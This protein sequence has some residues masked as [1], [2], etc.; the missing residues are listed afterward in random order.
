MKRKRT[1]DRVKELSERQVDKSRLPRA[2]S[3][4]LSKNNL[5]LIIAIVASSF[6]I[7]LYQ[8]NVQGLECEE[9][10]TIPAATGHHYIFFTSPPEARPTYVPV[11]IQE[12]KNLL[13]PDPDKSL[14]DVTDVLSRNVHM[15]LYFFLMHYW[16]KF[17]GTSEWS[18]RLP[19][20]IFGTLA[21]MMIFLLGRELI[22]PFVGLMSALL[23]AFMPDQ[24]Y[25]S[26][27]A[28]MYSL[29]VLLVTSSAYAIVITGKR[30]ASA[31]V[32]VLYALTSIAGLYTHYVYVFCFVSQVLFIWIVALL[33][34][35]NLRP[36]L[37]TQFS[38]VVASFPWFV[39]GLTQKQTSTDVI[40]W[41][42][43]S[44]PGG[45]ILREI[46]S[47]ITMLISVPE[48]PLGWLNVAV[49]YTLFA[50]GGV[51]LWHN[52]SAILLLCLWIVVPIAGIVFMDIFL[53]T[54][55]ISVIRYWMVITPAF[56][57]L[58]AA[59]VH[60]IRKPYQIP[61][62]AVLT[63]CLLIAAI[64][65]AKGQLRSK[66]D[67]HS[68]LG[69]FVDEQILDSEKEFVLTEGS[70]AIPL[71]LAYHGQ[72][73]MNILLFG[74]AMEKHKQQNYVEILKNGRNV[75]LLASGRSQAIRVLEASNYRRT[76]GPIRFGHILV[77][78]YAKTESDFN[79]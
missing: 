8:L 45:S 21:V 53:K 15:P 32:Y 70:N 63:M 48:A 34:K 77:Y 19:S 71:V 4:L 65:T 7:R 62:V 6:G 61:L 56:Y 54:H 20:V 25:F 52:R 10:Y 49:A 13:T 75:V 11:A 5:I 60:K 50:L 1:K 17:A 33:K 64:W 24:I 72:R 41:I 18:L 40:A 69:R 2:V 46:V 23:A 37:I 42:H 73:K 28:R 47:R 66:S 57:L 27:E 14:G 31:S 38:V 22:N 26:Q 68:K 78:R 51:F 3:D 36:W 67:E 58:I 30:P 9:F 74:W 79:K 43:G 55:A 35:E 12:Y 16:V 76:A 44:P 59:G 39:V 29:L